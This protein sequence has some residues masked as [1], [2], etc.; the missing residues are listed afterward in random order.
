MAYHANIFKLN[1]LLAESGLHGG[2]VLLEFKTATLTAGTA[3]VP[4]SFAN[5][6][7]IGAVIT[8]IGSASVN[9]LDPF[10]TD[11]VVTT[12]AVTVSGKTGSTATVFVVW[13]ARPQI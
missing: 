13:V 3:E 12:G 7:L 4:T 8:N 1:Q 11:L 2:D 5:G 6:Q 10:N 9:D